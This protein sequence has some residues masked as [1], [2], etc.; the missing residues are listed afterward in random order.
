VCELQTSGKSSGQDIKQKLMILKN[1]QRR[2][3][4]NFTAGALPTHTAW[5]NSTV[6]LFLSVLY[7]FFFS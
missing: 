7:F 2:D 4:L 5:S 1:I 6:S 3:L